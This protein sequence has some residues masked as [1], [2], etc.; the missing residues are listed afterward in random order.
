M[1]LWKLRDATR[2]IRWYTKLCVEEPD[3]RSYCR[4]HYGYLYDFILEYIIYIQIFFNEYCMTIARI[5]KIVLFL[6]KHN[7]PETGLTGARQVP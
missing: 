7:F 6:T 4:S 1:E 2:K 5:W 3:G